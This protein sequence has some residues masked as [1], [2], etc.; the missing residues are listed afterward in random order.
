MSKQLHRWGTL[1]L[2][3]FVA[4]MARAE[5]VTATWD[6]QNKVPATIVDV[7]IQGT[8]ASGSV[9]SDVEGISMKVLAQAEDVN[10]KLQY[11]AS[12]YAQF[13]SGTVLQIPVISASDVVTVVSYP[14]QSKYTVG[15][16]DATGQNTFTH[17]ATMDEAQQGYVEVIATATAYLYSLKVE[18]DTEAAADVLQDVTGT[19][20]YADATVM[21][22][23][24]ALSGSTEA[25]TVEAIEGNG[26]LMTV[27]ANGATFRN[28]GN[29]IQVR[30]GAVFKVPVKSTDDVVTVKGYPNYSYYAIGNNTTELNGENTYQAKV[31]DVQQGYV[32]VTSLNDNNYYYSISV[33]QKAQEPPVVLENEAA[34]ATFPFNLGTE[35]QTA[36]FGE[37]TD[38]FLGSKVTHGD[39]LWIKDTYTIGGVT[40]TRFEPYSQNNTPDATNEIRFVIQPKAGFAFTPSSVSLKTTRFGTD[41]G[42]LDIA[43]LNPDGTT[44]SLATEVKPVRNNDSAPVDELSYT[45]TGATPAEGGCG[46]VINLYH[47][48]DGKQIGFADIVITGELNGEEKEV[49]ILASFTA[50]GVEYLADDVFSANGDQFEGSIEVSKKETMISASNPLTNVTAATGEIGEI[51]YAGDETQCVVTIPMSAGDVNLDYVLTVVQKPDFTLTYYDTDRSVMGTQTVE[52]DAEIGTFEVDFNEGTCDEGYKVR[53]W[54]EKISGGRKFKVTDVITGNTALYAFATEI[55]VS[56]THKKY[57]YDLTDADFEPEDHEAFTPLSTGSYWH[58]KQHGWAFH[59]GERIALLVGPK[60]DIFVGV[61][62]YGKTSGEIVFYDEAG[63]EL[64]RVAAIDADSDGAVK[65]FKYEGE[66]GTIY[67]EYVTDGENYLHN[68]K[69][70]NNAETNYTAEGQWYFVKPGDASSLLDV[71]D[72]VNGNNAAADAERAYV[73]LPNGTYDLGYTVL[74]MISGNNVSIIGENR[75]KTIIRNAPE[76]DIEGLGKAALLQSSGKNLYFQDLTLRNDLDYYGAIGGGQVGG[77]AACFEDKGDRAVFKNVT[78]LSFQDT[79]YSQSTKQGYW[80]DCDIHGTVD[81]ICGGGDVRFQNTTI[82]LEKRNTNGTGGRTITAPTTTTN[83][84]YVFDGCQVVDLAEGKGDWNFGRT[85]QNNPICVFLNTTLDDNAKNTLVASRWTQKG[86]NSRDPKLFGEY[87]TMDA[88]GNDITP[89]SNTI[90]SFGG[91]F[92]TILTADQAAEFAYDKM[93][94]DWDPAALTVQMA[95]PANGKIEGNQISWDAVTGAEKYLVEKDGEFV[96]LTDEPS[97]TVEGEATDGYTVRAANASGGFGEAAEVTVVTGIETLSSDADVVKTE[98]FS[99]NGMR[100]NGLQHG[101]N[102]VV[103]T[104]ADGK[105]TTEKVVVE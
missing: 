74:T 14:G 11:N 5:I 8:N 66:P 37:A 4:V 60:A 55:E 33:V 31:S 17:T 53:G 97:Y 26:L 22:Q 16:E 52:K 76:R 62:K 81:F 27:E 83:F 28:N 101:L 23:T 42:L 48:Q 35:G 12:G 49:P 69:I 25:G 54:Y 1:C 29:N 45:I 87:H 86:M 50:N 63:T 85:W 9:A 44:V 89:S 18:Q 78:L 94:T 82:S 36:E 102:I 72:A 41:N 19:W 77:R 21:S 58:D 64:G 39:G 47:L 80:E 32:A 96:A 75:E 98:I 68:L 38:Y 103:K 95:A 40:E 34:T 99:A 10:I 71:I 90:T 73:F 79:Y 57:T 92:Q 20:D 105:K 88:N 67:M 3:A 7:N 104:A 13:N 15:G 65:A 30:S 84:G 51:T 2:L 24:V 46:L 70:I 43:W 100:Q 93:F 59:S 56:S 61:C 6:F 91:D